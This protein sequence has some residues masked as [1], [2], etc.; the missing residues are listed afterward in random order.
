MMLGIFGTI[1]ITTGDS[2]IKVVKSIFI[3]KEK[4]EEDAKNYAL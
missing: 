4:E 3:E 1:F 2:I